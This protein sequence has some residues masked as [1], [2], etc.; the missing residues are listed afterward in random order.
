MHGAT[1]RI[2]DMAVNEGTY[3]SIWQCVVWMVQYLGT[4]VGCL[5]GVGGRESCECVMQVY[6]VG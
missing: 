3:Q 5:G 6:V 4:Q 2:S 1:M